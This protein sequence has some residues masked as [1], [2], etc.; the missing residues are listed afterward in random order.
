VTTRRVIVCLDVKDGRVVKGVKFE[1]LR[2]VGDPVELA[3]RA[4]ADGADEVVF[5][6][7]SATNEG[8][9]TMLEVARR[10][11]ERLF[12]P[13]TIGGGIGSVDDVTRALRSGADKVGL[14][15]AIVARPALITEAAE[16][17]GAQCVVASIDARREG[18]GW[19]VFTHGGKRAT[20]LDALAWAKE[21]V[22]LGAGEV[23]LTSIDRDG[24]RT[25]YD[26]ELTR[27]VADA[28]DVPVIA[29]GG[30]GCGAHLVDAFTLGGAEAALVAGI[31]HDGVTTL[32]VL[33]DEL[34]AAGLQ[35]RS[36]P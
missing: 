16:A 28:V 5:L 19:R 21:C 23:L 26:L 4:E 22:R 36:G 10:T 32:R 1:G 35:V 34:R 27:A 20:S 33:K 9:A 29:S 30:A 3:E 11:A 8:R 17:V 12:I 15:S 31:L 7:V 14:N 2:D 13:L 18:A 24:A 6:D 25:G